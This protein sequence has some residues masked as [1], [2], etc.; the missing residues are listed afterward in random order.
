MEI[1]PTLHRSGSAAAAI[2]PERLDVSIETPTTPRT[3]GEELSAETPSDQHA[4]GSAHATVSTHSTVSTLS[5]E[6]PTLARSVMREDSI[7][8]GIGI[9]ST[10]VRIRSPPANSGDAGV[11]PARAKFRTSP[12]EFAGCIGFWFRTRCE[13]VLV[14]WTGWQRC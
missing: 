2:S 4:G 11:L 12:L 9:T 8:I 5:A 7:G 10:S 14:G 13:L 1:S 3:A 6:P